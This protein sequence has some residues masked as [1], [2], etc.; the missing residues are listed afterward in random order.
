MRIRPLQG[1]VLIEVTPPPRQSAGGIA[2]PGDL[3]LP[4]A[5]VEQ[6]SHHPEK[7]ARNNVGVVK[8]IGAWPKTRKGLLRM[9]EYGVGAKVLF[10]PWRGTQM[11]RGVSERLRLLRQEDVLAVLG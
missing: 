4:P 1:Q 2:L 10:N 6:Q 11:E 5:V 9:P 3:S 8:A 7:P